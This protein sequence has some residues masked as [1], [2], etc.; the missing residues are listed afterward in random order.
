MKTVQQHPDGNVYVRVDGATYADTPANFAS[1]FGYP[2]PELPQ[3]MT[4]RIYDQ[5]RRHVLAG[6]TAAGAVTMGDEMPWP[7]GDQTIDNVEAGLSNQQA[8]AAAKTALA[9]E[10]DMGGTIKSIIGPE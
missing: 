1:D 9:P 7:L 5:G 8:R 6:E 3:G 2:L 10:F 4:E